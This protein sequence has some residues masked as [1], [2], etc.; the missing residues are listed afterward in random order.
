MRL[1]EKFELEVHEIGALEVIGNI[2][3]PRRETTLVPSPCVNCPFHLSDQ[4][5]LDEHR[6]TRCLS[7][8]CRDIALRGK[9]VRNDQ[10]N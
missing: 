7:I 10:R 9:E 4:V 8:L 1:I 2:D 6:S 5:K 3:C